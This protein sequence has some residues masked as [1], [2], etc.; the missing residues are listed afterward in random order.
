MNY[1]IKQIL[2]KQIEKM[3][4]I[5]RLP[6]GTYDN[7][8]ISNWEVI[9]QNEEDKLQVTYTFENGTTIKDR[10]GL[11]PDAQGKTI[12][13]KIAGILNRAT[14]YVGDGLS[15]TEFLDKLVKEEIKFKV[16]VTHKD[17]FIQIRIHTDMQ[18]VLSTPVNSID[19]IEVQET[20]EIETL[21]DDTGI[22]K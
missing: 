22:A 7:V 20:N 11:N 13:E 4:F 19:D 18:S 12:I 1:D 14:N 10:W 17:Q 16:D 15:I 6:V 5:D 2:S 9:K 3:S 21:E 8:K